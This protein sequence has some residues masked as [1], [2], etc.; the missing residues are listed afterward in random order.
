MAMD[1]II[2]M[3]MDMG[4]AMVITDTDQVVAPRR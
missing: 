4:M 1:T 3:V 2:G